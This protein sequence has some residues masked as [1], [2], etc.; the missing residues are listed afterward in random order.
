MESKSGKRIRKHKYK[1]T[2]EE[3]PPRKKIKAAA[4]EMMQHEVKAS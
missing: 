3:D 4:N 1:N 2:I